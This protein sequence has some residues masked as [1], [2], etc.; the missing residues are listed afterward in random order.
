LQAD[1]TLSYKTG[2]ACQLTKLLFL[3]PNFKQSSKKALNP[4]GL[5]KQD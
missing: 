1:G 4:N 2:F 3:T 5:K